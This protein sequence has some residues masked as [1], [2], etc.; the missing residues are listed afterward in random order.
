MP[1]SWYFF[2]FIPFAPVFRAAWQSSHLQPPKQPLRM[3]L[4]LIEVWSLMCSER[5]SWGWKSLLIPMLMNQESTW[6][7]GPVPHYKNAS[8]PW[9]TW[10]RLHW[11]LWA[12]IAIHMHSG[13]VFD[14]M[15]K[16]S[17][18]FCRQYPTQFIAAGRAFHS[19]APS[20]QHAKACW[21]DPYA[22]LLARSTVCSCI[23]VVVLFCI[24]LRE[25]SHRMLS[26]FG[27]RATV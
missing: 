20:R 15:A 21:F 18:A 13:D 4:I 24:F 6:G 19:L 22:Y 26:D 1:F 9:S 8:L 27:I 10:C 7:T 11:R 16:T 25:R 17:V 3:R 14:E 2:F 12:H 23:V 5:V